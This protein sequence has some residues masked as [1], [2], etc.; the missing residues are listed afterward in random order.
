MKTT[1]MSNEPQAAADH[2]EEHWTEI[3]R[4]IRAALTC[5]SAPSLVRLEVC[6]GSAGVVISGVVVMR[7]EAAIA[8]LVAKRHARGM[9]VF[10]R[11]CVAIPPKAPL[12][13]A[14]RKRDPVGTR[15]AVTGKNKT[16]P[17]QHGAKQHVQ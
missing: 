15:E 2:Y 6:V 10:S 13:G 3:E 14:E 12:S 5:N 16:Q 8:E 1:I 9:P 4:D 17:D 11:L 7:Y